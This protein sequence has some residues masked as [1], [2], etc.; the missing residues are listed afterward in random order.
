[1]RIE[2][3]KMLD[4]E[5]VLRKR[6]KLLRRNMLLFWIRM[7][8]QHVLQLERWRMHQWRMPYDSQIIWFAMLSLIFQTDPK[9][10]ANQTR[11]GLSCCS[12]GSSC[13]ISAEG[14]RMCVATCPTNPCYE[15]CCLSNQTCGI[16][17]RFWQSTTVGGALAA[18]TGGE[19]T[20][21][22][23]NCEFQFRF[24]YVF[25]QTALAS[26]AMQHAALLPRPVSLIPQTALQDV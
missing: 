19:Y 16:V 22:T 2:S 15:G 9:C 8:R 10:L 7:L 25:K 12:A 20:C 14:Y 23:C 1:M 17:S 18:R 5:H 13:V 6:S 3:T 24:S 26:R 11:C 21:T 4:I